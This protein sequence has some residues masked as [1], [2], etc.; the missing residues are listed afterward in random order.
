[1][2]RF[3]SNSNAAVFFREHH[4]FAVGRYSNLGH[5]LAFLGVKEIG[6]VTSTVKIVAILS[7]K[8]GSENELERCCV[9]WLHPLAPRSATSVTT[10]GGTSTTG[11]DSFSTSFTQTVVP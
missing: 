1:M 8:T 5:F 3:A 6:Q 2:M 4:R 7:A 10:Y 9:A 11:A